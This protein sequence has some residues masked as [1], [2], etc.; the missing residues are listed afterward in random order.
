[1][2]Y[3]HTVWLS[4]CI[5]YDKTKTWIRNWNHFILKYFRN[6]KKTMSVHFSHHAQVFW[7]I[8]LHVNS[9]SSVCRFVF[10]QHMENTV[11]NTK[12]TSQNSHKVI[13]NNKYFVHILFAQYA[14]IRSS[15]SV[16]HAVTQQMSRTI[17]VHLD[18][19]GIYPYGPDRTCMVWNTHIVWNIYIAAYT[20]LLA[21]V[22]FYIEFKKFVSQCVHASVSMSLEPVSMSLEPVSMRLEP[23]SMRLA[24]KII[25]HKLATLYTNSSGHINHY[26]RNDF[27]LD[28]LIL[29]FALA[30]EAKPSY[31]FLRLWF[32]WMK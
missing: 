7:L 11:K 17:R 12:Q 5:G 8:H 1:M 4:Y 30:S 28:L 26:W 20:L 13:I 14:S 9:M 21:L 23:V 27:D 16:Y 32:S 22:W 31:F 15:W 25:T 24:V 18:C 19:I 2:V 29:T 3:T 10:L 6:G